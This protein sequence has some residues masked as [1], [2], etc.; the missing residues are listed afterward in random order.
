MPRPRLLVVEDDPALLQGITDLLEMNGYGV[1]GAPD[2]V[3]ALAL[4]E[5][6]R[7]DLILS[8]IMMPG[9]DGY[10]LY[11]RVR[12]NPALAAVPFIFLTARGDK[13]DVRRGK[14]L[15][16]D[17]YITK[18]FEEADLL[19]AVR[20]KLARRRALD[21]S[22]EEE[23]AQL[24]RGILATLSHEFRT[25]LTYVINYA[26][27]LDKGEGEVSPEEFRQFMQGIRKGADRLHRLVV[28]FITL[29]ELQTGEARTVLQFRRR[30]IDDMGPWLRI[31]GKRYVETARARGL[32][33]AIDV[34]DGLPA[35]QI[36]EEYLAN[37]LGRLLDN[38]IKFSRP[39]SQRVA[40]RARAEPDAL[41]IEV[42]DDGIG[43][44]E[45]DVPA[46]FR[47]FTQLDRTRME[48]QGSGSGLAICKGLVE[49]HAGRVSLRSTPGV[50][51]TF[52][53]WLPLR[54]P[55]APPA[56]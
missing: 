17:D 13:T 16:A 14:E 18:P 11:E 36:D 40:L 10:E 52:T 15:G 42:E 24:K 41:R 45:A 39:D 35:L 32:A 53:V 28:D 37:A 26:D 4:L 2:A 34:P 25:P 51:S 43:I 1:W 29:V 55:E 33:L 30:W 22:R 6:E 31:L 19:A 54:P 38:A 8:D 27:L 5:N 9:I 44:Q 50:G 56:A 23:L 21:A 49:L 46:L 12:Q 7:P 3:A 47:M 48:Q 20:G